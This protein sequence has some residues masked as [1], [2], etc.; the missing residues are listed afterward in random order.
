MW[1]I[2]RVY[3]HL[4]DEA[5]EMTGLGG[6]RLK[7]AAVGGRSQYWA[8]TLARLIFAGQPHNCNVTWGEW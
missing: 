1:Y 7:I 8:S 3:R 6:L 2:T 5:A 4:W